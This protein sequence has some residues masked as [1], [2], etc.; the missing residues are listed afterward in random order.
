MENNCCKPSMKGLFE[1]YP[2]VKNITEKAEEIE[3]QEQQAIAR[4]V[5]LLNNCDLGK[6]DALRDRESVK[7]QVIRRLGTIA[8]KNTQAIDVLL[9]ILINGTVF[10]RYLVVET[11]SKIAVGNEKV[12]TALVKI[13]YSSQ[14]KVTINC[15]TN[16]LGNIAK[17]RPHAVRALIYL[18]KNNN[19]LSQKSRIAR[20]LNQ[21]AEGHPQAI[22]AWLDIIAH[23]KSYAIR[24]SAVRHL[25]QVAVGN[26]VVIEELK[27]IARKKGQNKSAIEGKK[28]ARIGLKQIDRHNKARSIANKLFYL[29]K[30]LTVRLAFIRAVSIILLQFLNFTVYLVFNPLHK[31]LYRFRG[32][33]CYRKSDRKTANRRRSHG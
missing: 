9:E 13:I 8:Q 1:Q 4:L 12:I 28:I 33:K 31:I 24:C 22:I 16:I 17:D 10:S 18:L 11:I 14:D 21:I 25:S 26:K 3:K 19:D 32:K 29:L 15:A 7:L 23:G 20:Q 5:V 30:H 27:K 6:A 2:N